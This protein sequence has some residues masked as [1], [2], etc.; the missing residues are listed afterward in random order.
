M[1]GIELTKTQI[2]NKWDKLKIDW[3]IWHR[4]MEPN[5]PKEKFNRIHARVRNSIER[6]FG[7]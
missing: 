3:T 5:T 6:S 2:K 1:T 7:V 4:G